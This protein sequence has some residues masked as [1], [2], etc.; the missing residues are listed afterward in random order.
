M[1]IQS[2]KDLIVWQKAMEL[3]RAV[4]TLTDTFPREE[5][6]GITSQ[7]KRAA[8]S[9]PSNI[10]EGSRRGTKKDYRHFLLN[11]FGSG[12]EL[13]TQIEL[14][15]QLPF[16]KQAPKGFTLVELLLY[17]G[18]AATILI[19]LSVFS[20]ETLAARV[21]NQTIAEVEE[22]GR[23]V[24]QLITQ[25][26]RNADSIIAPATST[27]GASLS[28]SM[29][30]ATISPTIFDLASATLRL[31]EGDGAPVLLTNTR[32]TANFTIRNLSRASTPGTIG[33]QLTVTHVNPDQRAEYEFTKTFYG[34][35]SLR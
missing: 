23:A 33:I 10:A 34:S 7:M 32:V 1:K 9:I 24:L 4:Y 15:K 22:Q 14:V 6:Y 25:A 17:I 19:S 13:E 35:A 18:L 20:A 28:L 2:Y 3:A 12:A 5:I 21:K 26:V 16:G 29:A 31:R 30:D 11:A 8:V 27:S